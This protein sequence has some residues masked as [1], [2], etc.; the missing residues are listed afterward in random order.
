MGLLL[1]GRIY[2]KKETKSLI[3]LI[4]SSIAEFFKEEM[5]D[6]HLLKIDILEF[7]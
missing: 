5:G 1:L 7:N 4:I 6:S 3:R 2:T